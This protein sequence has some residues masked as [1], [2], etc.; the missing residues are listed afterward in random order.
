MFSEDTEMENYPEIG[1]KES[2]INLPPCSQTR[3]LQNAKV[4]S[5]LFQ[6]FKISRLSNNSL[7]VVFL[8]KKICC[9]N[10]FI[11]KFMKRVNQT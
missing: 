8:K 10:I 3:K 5:K 4:T 6:R 11:L 1:L 9:E 2:E 7:M